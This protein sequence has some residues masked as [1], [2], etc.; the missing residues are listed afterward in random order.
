MDRIVK[1][2]A[3][4]KEPKKKAY[5]VGDVIRCDDGS[6]DVLLRINPDGSG[7]WGNDGVRYCAD[8]HVVPGRL[9]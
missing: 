2:T 6:Y 1:P 7:T 4:P 8:G 3:S 9:G 5:K